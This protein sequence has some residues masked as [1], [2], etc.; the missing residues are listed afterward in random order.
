MKNIDE[1]FDT[2]KEVWMAMLVDKAYETGGDV[3]DCEMVLEPS[4]KY[5]ISQDYL[6][7]FDKEK[8]MRSPGCKLR[9]TELLHQF[10]EWYKNE[11]GTKSPAS[12][13]IEE[14]IDKKYGKRPKSGKWENIAIIYDDEGEDDME[15]EL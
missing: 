8:I 4:N 3:S 12:R 14:Y 1:K 13:E 10:K 7:K 15:D 6:A 5:R 9:K 2:W 11:F